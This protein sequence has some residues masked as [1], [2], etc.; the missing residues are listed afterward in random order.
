[1]RIVGASGPAVSFTSAARRATGDRREPE[2]QEAQVRALIPVGAAAA[3]DRS[4]PLT[5]HPAAP[6]LAQLIATQMQAPQTRARRRAEPEDAI[7]V[8]RSMTKPVTQ[9]RSFG[10]RV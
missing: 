10:K 9:R 7:A 5:R 8:Y 6:F 4:A 1:M 2:A 3:S